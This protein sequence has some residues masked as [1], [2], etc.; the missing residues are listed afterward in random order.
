M[1]HV[2]IQGLGQL[3]LHSP[4]EAYSQPESIDIFYISQQKHCKVPI[5]STSVRSF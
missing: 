3:D 5:K 4:G 2:S 1:P